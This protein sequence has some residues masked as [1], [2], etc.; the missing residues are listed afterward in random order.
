MKDFFY[1]IFRKLFLHNI[2]Y[3]KKQAVFKAI[4]DYRE[5]QLLIKIQIE[6][7]ELVKFV[8]KRVV[9]FSD[10]NEQPIVG[11][12]I[13][14]HVCSRAGDNVLVVVNEQNNE[15]VMVF[16]KV[17]EATPEVLEFVKRLESKHWLAV[18]YKM[19]KFNES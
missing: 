13:R 4:S 2:E 3:E 1:R 14:L 19:K 15:E 5:E 7:D 17:F 16:G 8:G 10:E 18:L 6:T 11:Q 12:A 9:H